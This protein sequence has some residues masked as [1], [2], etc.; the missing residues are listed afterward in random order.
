MSKVF[1]TS[2]AHFSH[3]QPFVWE[4]RGYESVERMNEEQIRKWNEVVGPE[5]EVWFLGDG[6]M[7]DNVTGAQCFSKLNGN[8]YI[9][10]GN[11]DTP[12]R[13]KIYK[14]MGF[15][16]QDGK[17]FTYKKKNFILSHEPVI[18]S[19]G[20]F[21]GW[22]D[23]INLH[24]HTHQ[25]SN[26]TNGYPLMYHVG[27]DSHDGYPVLLDDIIEEISNHWTELNLI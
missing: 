22:R 27:V 17:R 23:T 12:A 13:I 7:N 14:D 10:T 11:H 5:D 21:K 16:V 3:I 25:T 4:A 9:I 8:I 15:E 24:G 2:D 20:S 6:M 26:F 19:N 1:L 18:T